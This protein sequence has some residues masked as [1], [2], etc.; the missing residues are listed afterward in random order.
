[1]SCWY[2][3]YV[4]HVLSPTF[5]L[6]LRLT[7][8]KDSSLFKMQNSDHENHTLFSGTYPPR[9]YEGV[10]HT[11]GLL[12]PSGHQGKGNSCLQLFQLH[13]D[14]TSSTKD[15]GQFRADYEWML[16]NEKS[17][18]L[19]WVLLW[20][21]SPSSLSTLFTTHASLSICSTIAGHILWNESWFNWLESME[22][23]AN[24]ALAE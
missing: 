11:P 18:Y 16:I 14:V 21:I 10:P 8:Q 19:P 17:K 23:D 24:R 7:V 5:T 12:V 20:V 2:R 9:L 22:K 15:T 3:S 1:M 4:G 13:D 6:F